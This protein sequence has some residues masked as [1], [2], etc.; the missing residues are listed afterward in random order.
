VPRL[1]AA[2]S[3]CF[4]PVRIEAAFGENSSGIF[5]AAMGDSFAPPRSDRSYRNSCV[6]LKQE[7]QL[8]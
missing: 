4:Q 2:K 8:A 6:S 3:C 5:F 7:A 1:D